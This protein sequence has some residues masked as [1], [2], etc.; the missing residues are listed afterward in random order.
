MMM[1]LNSDV[2]SYLYLELQKL[3]VLNC[4]LQHSAHVN[5]QMQEKNLSSVFTQ[6][7]E[8]SWT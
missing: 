3:D 7:F 2:K 8:D 5:L 6:T 1:C 4:F